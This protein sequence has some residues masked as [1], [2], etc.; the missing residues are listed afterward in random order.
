MQ[1]AGEETVRQRLKT[2]LIDYDDLAAAHYGGVMGEELADRLAF[3]FAAF[4]RNR[5]RLVEAAMLKLT[6]GESPDLGTIWSVLDSAE[7]DELTEEAV[8]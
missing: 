4:K 3:D 7:S 8:M 1:W 2:H 6:D 5:A